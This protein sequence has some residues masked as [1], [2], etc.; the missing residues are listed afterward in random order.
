MNQDTTDK[1]S[2]WEHII[3]INNIDLSNSFSIITVTQIKNS[4]ELWNGHPNQF[5]PRFGWKM[6]K[7]SSRPRIFM[8]NNIFLLQ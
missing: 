1:N 3:K 2:I 6:D 4:K 5:K 8:D 7:S